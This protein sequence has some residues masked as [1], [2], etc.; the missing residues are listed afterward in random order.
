MRGYWKMA[1]AAAFAACLLMMPRQAAD[2]ARAAMET[3]AR[4]VLPAA[5]PFA[6]VMPFLTCGE[7]RKVYD[8]LL[9]GV[10][11]W[12]FDLPG[13]CASAIVAGLLAGSPA[14][15]MAV[16]RVA[17]DEHLTAGQTARLAGIACGVSPAYV[18]SALGVLLA[19]STE[20]GWRLEI[21][22]ALSLLTT[23]MLFRSRWRDA[24]DVCET[25][26]IYKEENPVAAAA[27]AMLRVCGYMILFSVGLE[28]AASLLGE[29]V[30]PLSLLL[31]LPSGAA[32]AAKN[33]LP[34][35]WTAAALG[36]GGLC[37]LEQC[38]GILRDCG[39]RWRWLLEQKITSG[40]LCAGFYV[41]VTKSGLSLRGE[42]NWE[43]MCLLLLVLMVPILTVFVGKRRKKIYS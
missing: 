27:M 8:R 30:K 34:T 10:V 17:R 16:A 25:Y 38:M 4:F 33:G 15:A 5:F 40:I 24:D 21:A 12:L 7:A 13:G 9:G 6:A 26:P 28:V 18:I 37:I 3:W 19:G 2:A 41:L 23:G 1:M 29:K 32:Y 43:S 11:R 20:I 42:P 35:V 36:F 14:G 39:V 22:Q 31:D